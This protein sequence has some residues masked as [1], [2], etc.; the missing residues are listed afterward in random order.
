MHHNQKINQ[1]A[2]PRT[3]TSLTILKWFEVEF[4]HKTPTYKCHSERQSS[5][6]IQIIITKINKVIPQSQQLSRLQGP[7]VLSGCQ[8]AHFQVLSLPVQSNATIY[9]RS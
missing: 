4:T 9:I 8:G 2:A 6:T 7:D 1:A 3:L 5:Q